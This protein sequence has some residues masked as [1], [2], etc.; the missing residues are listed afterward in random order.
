MHSASR[1]SVASLIALFSAV[2]ANAQNSSGTTY[3]APPAHSHT[4]KGVLRAR[5]CPPVPYP[6]DSLKNG[7]S[8]KGLI[9]VEIAPN[10]QVVRSQLAASSG[11]AELDAAALAVMQRCEFT[12]SFDN[13]RRIG[14]TLTVEFVWSLT[15]APSVTFDSK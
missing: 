15:P 5:S 6:E 8:G 10:A 2:Q 12:S 13:G 3:V 14:D 4:G 1:L 9:S 11:F 7:H